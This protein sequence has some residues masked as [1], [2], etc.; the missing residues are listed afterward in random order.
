MITTCFLKA[1]GCS[2]ACVPCLT[3]ERRS[4]ASASLLFTSWLPSS[5]FSSMVHFVLLTQSFFGASKKSP[6]Q[7]GGNNDKQHVWVGRTLDMQSE[8]QGRL[9]CLCNG[10]I[11]ICCFQGAMTLGLESS[12]SGSWAPLLFHDEV[13]T[14]CIVIS[15]NPVIRWQRPRLGLSLSWAG[16]GNACC[17]AT[18][19]LGEVTWSEAGYILLT[20]G[21]GWG[22][23][24]RGE[25]SGPHWKPVQGVQN[26][27][28]IVPLLT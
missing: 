28:A 6:P 13:V 12:L 20:S 22:W 2:K 25:K 17:G 7:R 23:L 4:F 1:P 26:Q 19:S 9:A 24:W 10:R 14:F 11:L 5:A 18:T 8:N 16:D 15:C 21:E 27:P 3:C